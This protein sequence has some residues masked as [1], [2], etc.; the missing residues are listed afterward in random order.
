MAGLYIHIP[1]CKKACHYC[2]FHFTQSVGQIDAMVDAIADE[3]VMQSDFLGRDTVYTVYFGGGTPSL[4][5]GP[6]LKKLMRIIQHEYA[7]SSNPE[8]TIEANPDDL[9]KEKLSTFF[10]HGVNRLSIG[11]QSFNDDQLKWMNRQHS[12][13]QAMDTFYLARQMGFENI[14]LDLIYALPSENHDNWL[15][16]LKMITTLRPEHISSYCLTIEPQTAFG[17]W[18]KKGK[19]KAIDEDFAADQFEILLEIMSKYGYE[20]YE[21]SN[22]AQPGYESQHNSA[23]WKDEKYLGIGPSAHSYNGKFRKANVANN[24]KYLKGIE[25]GEI[26]FEVI[27]L[28]LEDQV[29]E[30][31]LTSLRTKWGCDLSLLKA[32]YEVD[33]LAEQEH[34]LNKLAGKG[35]IFEDEG[36]LVL[37]DQGKLLADKIASDLFIESD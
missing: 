16:D 25:E 21:I 17:N 33:L 36:F 34:Y 3:L 31:I 9:D 35:L 27:T 30:Y 28:S 37:T 7:L 13:S 29:N 14:S 2:D 32:K 4:L 11:V 8:I 10:D 6:H 24:A 22:F 26:P 12:S 23:Y 20:Q 19:I 18:L 15:R 5:E 1:F